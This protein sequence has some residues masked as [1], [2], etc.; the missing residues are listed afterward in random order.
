M[1]AFG[2][3]GKQNDNLPEDELENSASLPP[4]ISNTKKIGFRSSTPT[5]K[6]A[7]DM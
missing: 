3:L 6:K 2:R 5:L 4:L 7:P 1:S